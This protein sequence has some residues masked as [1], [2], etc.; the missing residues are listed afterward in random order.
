MCKSA[1]AGSTRVT[2]RRI[3]LLI[4]PGESGRERGPRRLHPRPREAAPGAPRLPGLGPS[5][6]GLGRACS[7]GSGS[8]RGRGGRF[9]GL[10]LISAE[11]GP[12]PGRRCLRGAGPQVG[13]FA[14]RRLDVERGQT[15]LAEWEVGS[16]GLRKGQGRPYVKKEKIFFQRSLIHSFFS[17]VK[18]TCSRKKKPGSILTGP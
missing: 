14:P 10:A 11:P 2:G 7:P 18:I 13:F 5:L 3:S 8:G 16:H 4:T 1:R 12:R 6:R 15:A 9:L 17:R